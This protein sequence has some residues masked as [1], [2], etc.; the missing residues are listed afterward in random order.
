M[1]E[2]LFLGLLFLFTLLLTFTI[3]QWL[4]QRQEQAEQRLHSGDS[5]TVV[6]DRPTMV[7]GGLTPALGETPMSQSRQDALRKE[8]REAGYYRPTALLEYRALRTVFII[9]PIFAA[10]VACI[11][12]DNARVGPVLGIGALAAILGFSLPRLY[13][14]YVARQRS[15][16]IERGL[17]VAVDLLT[18]GLS[19]GANIYASLGRVSKE[20]SKTYPVLSQELQIVQK[21]TEMGN[22]D[23][24]LQHFADRTS[25]QEVR[26]L[27]L[28]L[29]QS[30]RLG[31]DIST[32]LLEFSN[33]FRINMR[34]RAESQA[35]KASFWMLFPTILCLWIPAAI[36]LLGPVYYEFWRKR[37]E[38]RDMF[39]QNRGL[40]ES[41]GVPSGPNPINSIEDAFK[42]PVK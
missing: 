5:E 34:Q 3:F 40:I 14:N 39:R 33:N 20:M 24:A 21:Q 13:V 28:V 35:N 9:L 15:R 38:T 37:A 17:P 7:L 19:G 8:L 26:N 1:F 22:L 30:E 25:V 18:L 23:L 41:S 10:L 32:A 4:V 2:W 12:I 29:S 16:E 27:A 42:S 31:T 36:I 11:F 6:G